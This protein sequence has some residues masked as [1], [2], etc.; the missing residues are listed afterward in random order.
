MDDSTLM[1]PIERNIFTNRTLN[2]SSIQAIGYDMDYTLIHY[3][4]KQ[5]ER[6]M[7]E[8]LKRKLL[9]LGWPVESLEYVPEMIIRGLVLD[10]KFGNIVKPNRFG[11]VKRAFH[12]TQ[13]LDFGSMRKVYSRTTVDIR[14]DRWLLLT[15]LFDIPVAC[16]YSQLVDKLDRDEVPE[17]MGYADL[18][19]RIIGNL[20]AAYAE[21][22]LKKEILKDPARYVVEDTEISLAL[23]DQKHAGKKLLLIT[24]SE[25][26]FVS[27][28]M[29]Y[30]FDP[31]LQ[32]GMTWRDLFDMVIVSA[33]K[34]N[35]FLRDQP[36]FEVVTEKG[37]L[38][39]VIGSLKEDAIY[40][41]GHAKLVEEAFGL[42]GSQIMYIGDHVESDVH[43][44]KSILRWRTGLVLRELEEELACLYE[45]RDRQADLT[46]M[47]G[48]KANL[49][50]EQF[51]L[52]LFIQRIKRGYGPES[53]LLLNELNSQLKDL[54]QKIST[55]DER[56]KPL[57]K[58]AQEIFNPRWGLLTRAGFDKS[59]LA[60]QLEGYADIY[61][62][63]VSN[64][65]YQTPFAY[66]RS[67]RSSLPH[68]GGIIGGPH[69]GKW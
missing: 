59:Y 57:A 58:E 56:I 34:P 64:L 40:V 17:V 63:R 12:G 31:Q 24:N 46:F 66:L 13:P 1:I 18:A 49:E 9:E 60:R 55:L 50:R 52:R 16:M 48:K 10:K 51:Q 21:G 37:M 25:W 32:D 41:G 47:M 8:Y 4:V 23:L 39:P 2:M 45:F 44:S 27:G 61:M 19:E 43:V 67:T 26:E 11:Y 38:K 42:Q 6:T 35:F 68:D 29:A 5:W 33:D 7:Y 30:T 65:L 28:I 54:T 22:M 14:E 69:E 62:S 15:T 36:A 3:D 53:T 20:D